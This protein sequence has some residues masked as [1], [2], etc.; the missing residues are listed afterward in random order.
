MRTVSVTNQKGGVGKTATTFNLG[1]ALAALGRRVLLVDLDPQG[2][3]T[4]ALDLPGTAAPATLA[5]ALLGRWTGGLAALA[6]PTG[7]EGLHVVATNDDAFLVEQQ[8]G[9]LPGR[10]HRLGRLIDATRGYDVCLIDCPP[11]LGVLTDNALLA[12]AGRGGVL[13]PVQAEDS[14]LHALALLF[15]QCATL[16]WALKV[17]LTMLGMVVNLYDPRRGLIAKTTLKALRQVEE[18]PVLGVVG[19][20][21][22]VRR[23]WRTHRPVVADEPDCTAAM[24]YRALADA[25]AGAW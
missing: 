9:S 25:L 16:E 23:S 17:Q 21:T 3:L 22:A 5:E 24:Q 14:S 1:A 6:A 13:V 8:L 11:G 15:A 4:R 12:T 10:E 2:H 7:V 20:L 18:L 19:D